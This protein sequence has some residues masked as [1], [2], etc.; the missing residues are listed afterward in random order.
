MSGEC[1]DCG[2]HTI[3]CH[4]FDLEASIW[5]DTSKELPP[6]GEVV[7]CI[8]PEGWYYSKLGRDYFAL[9]TLENSVIWITPSLQDIDYNE[10]QVSHW[11][12]IVPD[13][14]GKKPY[15]K[16]IQH[17]KYWET[18]LYFESEN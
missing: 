9:V 5:H 6:I 15:V 13:I 4:C 18:E 8:A 14:R 2:E 11:R 3:D 12:H 1:D 10:L 17:E 16:V 7:E